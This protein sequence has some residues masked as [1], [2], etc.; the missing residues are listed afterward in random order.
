METLQ[1]G[2]LRADGLAKVE[3]I[4][5][6]YPG[7][8]TEWD[9]YFGSS[10]LGNFYHLGEKALEVEFGGKKN[11]FENAEAAFQALK[12]KDSAH[13]FETLDGDAAFRLK[14]SLEGQ[15]DWT[16]AGFGNNWLGMWH[17]LEKKFAPGSDLASKLLETGDAFLLE[18]NE[19]HGRDKIWSDNLDGS[20]QNWLGLQLMLIRDQLQK[21]TGKG[22]WTAWLSERLN[23]EDGSLHSDTKWQQMVEEAAQR[24]CMRFLGPGS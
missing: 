7:R 11:T 1:I 20:G 8:E 18:H 4:A 22:S 5:F 19:R 14:R 2:D 10:F 17:I 13:R 3:L 12:F 15:E 6:Y 24:V 21:R 23:L 16:Y 9:R